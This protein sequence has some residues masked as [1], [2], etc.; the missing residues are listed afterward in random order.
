MSAHTTSV[1]AKWQSA[2]TPIKVGIASGVAGGG[3]FLLLLC[4]ALPV[5]GLW[6]F[7]GEKDGGAGAPVNGGGAP[8]NG[9]G[10]KSTAMKVSSKEIQQ[11]YDANA[12]AADGKYKGKL[13]QIEGVLRSIDVDDDGKPRISVRDFSCH[14]EANRKGD[15]AILRKGQILA[16]EGILD[17]R[18]LQ[19]KKC[20]F[21]DAE[22]TK[23]DLSVF[24]LG[25]QWRDDFELSSARYLGKTIKLTGTIDAIQANRP[26]TFPPMELGGVRYAGRAT[27]RGSDMP[28]TC[29][30]DANRWADVPN[31]SKG[32]SVTVRGVL[33]NESLALKDCEL[34][35]PK[36]KPAKLEF[37]ASEL[38]QQWKNDPELTNAKYLGKRL[39]VTGKI[40]SIFYH[41][42]GRKG[43]GY[44]TLE[45]GIMGYVEE[46]HLKEFF[47]VSKLTKAQAVFSRGQTITISGTFSDETYGNLQDRI[48]RNCELVK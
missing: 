21:V 11:A 9:G 17:G 23:L 31:V 41:Y 13:V 29:Y 37:S 39:K 1:K 24:E 4:C 5:V 7:R 25:R 22:P 16:V 10:P 15:V 3:C 35:E 19:M 30:F 12:V 32:Q 33:V 40:A 34:L 44:V 47:D 28:C 38:F 2:T 27:L 26:N 42:D 36:L 20:K 18:S 6:T 8:A 46:G 14:F 48:M 43:T 45:G